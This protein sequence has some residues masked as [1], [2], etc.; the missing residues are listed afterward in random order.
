MLETILI[1]LIL[2][3]IVGGLLALEADTMLVSIISVG[4]LGFLRAIAFL[5]L[6]APDLAITQVVVEVVALVILI[7]ATLH[8]DFSPPA[9]RRPIVPRVLAVTLL[10]VV[11]VIGAGVFRDF[12]AFGTPAMDR[13]ADAPAGHYLQHGLAE[14]G[15][16][17][18]VTAVILD[19][20]AYDTLGEATVLF[21]S[22]LGALTILRRRAR[23]GH[24]A[25]GKEAATS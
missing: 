5:M 24:G 4:A 17:N 10:L 22:I 18:L 14:T 15:A 20:R 16:A 3:M 2:L 19:Y 1:L 8:R 13:F 6:G 7:R 9:P 11:A 25:R 21:V 23:P 12:P